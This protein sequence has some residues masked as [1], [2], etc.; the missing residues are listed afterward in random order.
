MPTSPKT[1]AVVK[2]VAAKKRATTVN[3]PNAKKVSAKRAEAHIRYIHMAPQKVQ[4]V[5]A[6][7]HGLPVLEAEALLA[8]LPKRAGIPVT[9]ALRSARSNATHNYQMDAKKTVIEMIRVNE[10]MTLPRIM[11]RAQGRAYRIRKRFSH[12]DVVLVQKIETVKKKVA[13]SAKATVTK[14]TPVKVEPAKPKS[15][16]RETK[17]K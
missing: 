3:R 2:K 17:M 16:I 9:K 15:V 8:T 12:I 13:V 14:D 10:S 11:P 6:L 7:V 4:R 5:A 1:R